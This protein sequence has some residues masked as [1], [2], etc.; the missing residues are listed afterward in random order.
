MAYYTGTASHPDRAKAI[1][2]VI[3]VHVALAFVIL[4][5]L[6][7]RMI[8]AAVERMKTFDVTLPK[9]PPPPPPPKPAPKPEQA[10]KPAGAPAPRAVPTPVVA[11]PPKI[12]APSPIPAAKIAVTGSASSSGAGAAGNGTGAGGAGYG[13]GGGGN[14]GFTPAQ[15][16]SKIPNSEYRRLVAASGMDRGTVG[17]SIR[18]T[19]DGRAANCR[20]VRSSGNS[21]ADSLMCQLTEEY[22]RFRPALDPNGRPVA[23]DVTWYPNWFR[24]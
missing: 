7:V 18:V 12:P 13:P 21:Y 22:V 5:G 14:G 1:T 15:K 24:P 2:A 9:P 6:N 10:K 23:Q 16:I 19:P 17:I 4:S 20:V 8:S 3:A 11:P